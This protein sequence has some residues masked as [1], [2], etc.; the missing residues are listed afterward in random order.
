M[1]ASAF[2]I[3]AVTYAAAQVAQKVT[4][5][6]SES[7]WTAVKSG[8]KKTFGG[9]PAMPDVNAASLAA[10][11]KQ[12]P[13]IPEALAKLVGQ[14][15]ALRRLERV[16]EVI[17][18]ARILWIDDHPEWNSWEIAC[19]EAAGASVRTVSTTQS[20]LGFVDHGYDAI[21]SDI[22]REGSTTA[23][24]TALPSLR[25]AA[26][27]TPIILYVGHVDPLGVPVGAFGITDRPDE[28]LHLV[29]DALERGRP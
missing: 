21:V 20:A 25:A 23:G 19:L 28:L 15:S 4:D 1:D 16:H 29:L 8:W 18:G 11:T 9:E 10:I 7:L 2:L 6:M 17:N 13:D 22:D 24:L 3:A 12:A 5:E 14:S 27:T 26:P